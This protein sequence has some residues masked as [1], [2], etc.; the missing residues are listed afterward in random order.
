MSPY[1]KRVKD[2]NTSKTIIIDRYEDL[3]DYDETIHSYAMEASTGYSTFPHEQNVAKNIHEYG[4]EP[5]LIYIVRNPFDRIES[6]YNFSR[7]FS[8]ADIITKYSINYSKYNLQLEQYR[9]Y[10]N[11]ENILVIDFD[12]LK[13]NSFSLQR[14]VYDFL[15]LPDTDFPDKYPV[16][17][18]TS[19]DSKS[20]KRI[21]TMQE[22]NYIHKEL[23]IDM[24][25]LHVNYGI[26][27]QKWGFDT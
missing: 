15:S 25:N 16:V 23:Q 8:R 9:K 11:A 24:S 10:F 7:R 18:S 5:K 19:I 2:L 4:L 1:S 21:L 26:D 12:E 17:N 22:R 27:V 20:K 6:Q 3:W 13:N 14:T